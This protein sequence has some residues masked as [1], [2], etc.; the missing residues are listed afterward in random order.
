MITGRLGLPHTWEV[1]SRQV[2]AALGGAHKEGH[3]GEGPAV[4]Q[5]GGHQ[6]VPRQL[7]QAEDCLGYLSLWGKLG[8]LGLDLAGPKTSPPPRH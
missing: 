2:P 6:G 4:P 7:A 8:I 5:P 1:G 3:L